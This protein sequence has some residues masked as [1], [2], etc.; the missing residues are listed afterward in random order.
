MRSFESGTRA[1]VRV[2]HTGL[3]TRTGGG[4]ETNQFTTKN[5]CTHDGRSVLHNNMTRRA[6]NA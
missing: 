4:V 5:I 2:L 1:G 6:V 3:N